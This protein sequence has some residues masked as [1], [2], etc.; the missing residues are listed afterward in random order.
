MRFGVLFST[1]E[2]NSTFVK[3]R[4]FAFLILVGQMIEL[5]AVRS[6]VGRFTLR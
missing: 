2:V 3:R 5:K 6:A 1:A 4:E